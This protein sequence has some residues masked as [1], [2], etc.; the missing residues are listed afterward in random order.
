[1]ARIAKELGTTVARVALAWVQSRP[2]VAS[3][4][5]GARTLD[6]LNDNL[7]ALDVQLQAG[8]VEKLNGLTK[9]TLDFPAEF[10]ASGAPILHGG[11]TIN[12]RSFPVWPMS[13]EGDSDRY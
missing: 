1:M 3:T 13:P 11:T 6:Q 12:G 8:Q 2:G 9:P 10:I 4:I 7:A 5:I